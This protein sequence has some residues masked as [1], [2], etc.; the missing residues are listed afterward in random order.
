MFHKHL[1]HIFALAVA[2]MTLAACDSYTDDNWQPGEQ[3]AQGVQGAFFGTGNATSFSV[4][5]DTNFSITVSR[6]DST[7][8]ATVGISVVSRDTTAINIPSSVTF[9]AG[10][11]TA[12]LE[13]S[14]EG[15]VED[16]I[17]SFT[18]AVDGAQVNPYAAGST[19]FTA[20]V[21]N[22][23][24]WKKVIK[25]APTYYYYDGKYTW[26]YT[27]KTTIE[28]YLNTNYF[29]VD[30]FLNSGAGF[31]FKIKNADGTFPETIDDITAIDGIFD[32][33]DQEGTSISDY[34]YYT[35]GSFYVGDS[36][37]FTDEVNGVTYDSWSFYGGSTDYAGF[38][39][40]SKYIELMCL[41][42][43]G[44]KSSFSTLY[45]DWR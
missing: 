22:G 12:T 45:I 37:S 10:K 30:N 20:T 13:C 21:I 4:S 39:G 5:E 26:N 33:V 7:E 42:A 3:V 24:L 38:Y 43:I 31:Y 41:P 40:T 6:V 9:E 35:F 2:A 28:Q 34:G 16:S 25:D 44:G 32:P 19:S 17:Y 36:W 14:A 18:I 15:L 27:Y 11:G 8:A 29:Y 1:N 23:S